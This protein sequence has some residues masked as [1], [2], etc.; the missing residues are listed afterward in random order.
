M[1]RRRAPVPFARLAVGLLLVAG[2]NAAAPYPAG[3]VLDHA[4]T[5]VGSPGLYNGLDVQDFFGASVAWAGDLDGDGSTDFLVGSPWDNDGF[6]GGIGQ[7]AVWC[8]RASPTEA[9]L[10]GSKLGRTSGA[11]GEALWFNG[12]FGSAVDRIGDLDGDGVG[13]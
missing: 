11:L 6:G 13:E 1:T 4:A 8:V 10:G 2:P 7:G 9:V 3:R 5:S 12:R